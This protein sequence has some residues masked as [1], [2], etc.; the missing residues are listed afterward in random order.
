[1]IHNKNLCIQKLLL[2]D[3]NYLYCISYIMYKLRYLLFQINNL[4]IFKTNKFYELF[5]FYFI[6]NNINFK[7]NLT[8]I[9]KML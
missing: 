5:L 1:M 9:N 6:K 8:L 4:K 2:Y 3:Y 7:N